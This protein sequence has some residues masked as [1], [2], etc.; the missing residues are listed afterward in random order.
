MTAIELISYETKDYTRAELEKYL[1]H[2]EAL[3]ESKELILNQKWDILE[4]L[5]TT[6]EIEEILKVCDNLLRESESES[7][8]SFWFESSSAEESGV[9]VNDIY[10]IYAG[11]YGEAGEDHYEIIF[12]GYR[13]SWS[14]SQPFSSWSEGTIEKIQNNP[15]R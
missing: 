13:L 2:F 6:S 11:E 9:E 4:N 1:D 15:Q 3:K 5:S 10:E 8:E 12:N 7:L 14:I